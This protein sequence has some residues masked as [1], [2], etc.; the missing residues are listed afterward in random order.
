[1]PRKHFWIQAETGWKGTT[2]HKTGW[3]WYDLG[4]IWKHFQTDTVPK[5]AASQVFWNGKDKG[6]CM[7]FCD[8]KQARSNAFKRLWKVTLTP[9]SSCQL[10]TSGLLGKEVLKRTFRISLPLGEV[11]HKLYA[12]QKDLGIYTE[13]SFRPK[14]LGCWKHIQIKLQALVTLHFPL[15]ASLYKCLVFPKYVTWKCITAISI[16]VSSF[17]YYSRNILIFLCTVVW[18]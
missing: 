3:G 9:L 12:E 7:P 13:L 8:W 2:N 5:Q 15:Q 6:G 18:N 14:Y 11:S 10:C 4:Y 16:L 1:M 17:H